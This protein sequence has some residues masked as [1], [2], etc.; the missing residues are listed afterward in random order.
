M[1]RQFAAIAAPGPA[2]NNWWIAKL[3]SVDAVTGKMTETYKPPAGQQI[4]VPR[5]SP[6]GAR[7][8]FIGGI[9]SDEGFLGGDIYS[10]DAAGG[11]AKNLTPGIKISA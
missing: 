5:W 8:A 9:M 3:Y 6:D 1:D 2:D 10:V 4:A 11:T 7:I